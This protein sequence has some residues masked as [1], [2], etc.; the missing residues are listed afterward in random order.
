MTG[1]IMMTAVAVTIGAVV[2]IPADV[3]TSSLY[4]NNGAQEVNCLFHAENQMTKKWQKDGE[5]MTRKCVCIA[6]VNML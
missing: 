6:N 4:D 1:T 2:I 5:R 3:M